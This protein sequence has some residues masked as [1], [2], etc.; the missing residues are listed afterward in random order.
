M[1]IAISDGGLRVKLASWCPQP[2]IRNR[3]AD[4]LWLGRAIRPV[5]PILRAR[6]VRYAP[7]VAVPAVEAVH[8]ERPEARAA[9]DNQPVSIPHVH[10]ERALA[11]KVHTGCGVVVPD[12]VRVRRVHHV[13]DLELVLV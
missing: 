9:G 4:L 12:G 6:D 8:P 1:A 3:S 5:V 2:A 13:E 10:A 11:A 7:L